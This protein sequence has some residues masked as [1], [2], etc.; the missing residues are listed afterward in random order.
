M[1]VPPTSREAFESVKPYVINT[2]Q[3]KV[4]ETFKK[5]GEATADEVM[6]SGGFKDKQ[7][8][9]RRFSELVKLGI[10]ELAGK[11]RKTPSNRNA[12]VY[13]LVVRKEAVVSERVTLSEVN[14]NIE[15]LHHQI[16]LF[17]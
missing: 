11:Q 1:K 10:L 14:K 6:V 13:R 2:D 16:S 15:K 4:I 17:S 12:E 3:K 5:I 7:T 9:Q 8:C